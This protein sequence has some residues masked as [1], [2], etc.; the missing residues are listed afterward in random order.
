[1]CVA[2]RRSKASLFFALPPA[3]ARLYPHLS[4]LLPT[5]KSAFTLVGNSV[6]LVVVDA[7]VLL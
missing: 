7:M 6:S 3:S 2:A 5:S 4:Y 1:M